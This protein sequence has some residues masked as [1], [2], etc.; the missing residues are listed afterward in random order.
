MF[1]E[2]NKI[3]SNE[4]T[5]LGSKT[6]DKENSKVLSQKSKTWNVVKPS[7]VNFKEIQCDQ[8]KD[9]IYEEMYYSDQEKYLLLLTSIKDKLL[10]GHPV[11][12]NIIISLET[13]RCEINWELEKLIELEYIES[14]EQTILNEMK[15]WER[16]MEPYIKKIEPF[17]AEEDYDD[18]KH[19]ESD[20]VGYYIIK[21]YCKYD[22]FIKHSFDLC[23]KKN[24]IQEEMKKYKQKSL[25]YKKYKKILC[26]EIMSL[27]NKNR[28][29]YQS[30][31]NAMTQMQSKVMD[32]YFCL[33]QCM[34]TG[35]IEDPRM[36]LFFTINGSYGHFPMIC[37]QIILNYSTDSNRNLL[38]QFTHATNNQFVTIWNQMTRKYTKICKNSCCH[39]Y[40][41]IC[42][43]NIH[44]LP[45]NFEF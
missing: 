9:K 1:N 37:W 26:N 4:H 8:L 34:M 39:T 16:N 5:M 20:C 35:E 30:F 36:Q 15:E 18:W 25:Q 31:H 3:K 38:N 29:Q 12:Q 17:S 27:I 14:I 40:Q 23:E 2:S 41:G 11:E 44:Q 28:K 42:Y 7:M 10:L 45:N 32:G 19:T 21:Y 24:I 22:I 43:K 33:E 13:Y 6:S